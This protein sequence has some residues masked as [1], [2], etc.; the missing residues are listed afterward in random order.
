MEK[1]RADPDWGLISQWEGEIATWQ[2][3][4]RRLRHRL[5]RDW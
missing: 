1:A 5:E 3:E 4:I 2:E